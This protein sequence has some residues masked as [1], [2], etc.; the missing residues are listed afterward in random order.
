MA[1]ADS[2]QQCFLAEWYRPAVVNRDIGEVAATLGDTVARL[3]GQGHPIRLLMTVAASTDQVLYGLFA[4]ESADTVAE[5]CRDAGWP[6]DRITG[7]VRA[8]IPP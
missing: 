5:A 7:N 1:V 4:A 6:A 2:Q 8:H 3:H